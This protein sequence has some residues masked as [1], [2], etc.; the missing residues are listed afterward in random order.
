MLPMLFVVSLR[1]KTL[2]KKIN[3]KFANEKSQLVLLN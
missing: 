3:E 1:K 2:V